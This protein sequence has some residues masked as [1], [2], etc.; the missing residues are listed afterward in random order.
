M[1]EFLRATEGP[2]QD[3]RAMCAL[4]SEDFV[5]QIN[6]PSAPVIVGRDAARAEIE[7]QNTVSTGMQ[8]GSEVRSIAS[9]EDTVFT[10]RLDVVGI[11]GKTISFHINGVFE[12]RNGEIC[13]WREYFDSADPAQRLGIDPKL[14]YAGVGAS[15]RGT[16]S[17]RA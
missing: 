2:T 7:R 17:G 10:E 14:F 4:M 3:V 12:V 5:W 8:P 15:G 6:V 13:A 11:A 16:N 9:N 1:L